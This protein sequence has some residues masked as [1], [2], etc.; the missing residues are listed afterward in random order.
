MS[1]GE[2]LRNE[3]RLLR[4]KLSEVEVE[5][6]K[7]VEV[8]ERDESAA[9]KKAGKTSTLP[10]GLPSTAKK[11]PNQ[12]TL[13][14]YPKHFLDTKFC[15][16]FQNI[17]SFQQ[18]ADDSSAAQLIRQADVN[19]LKDAQAGRIQVAHNFK[20]LFNSA[21]RIA[22]LNTFRQVAGAGRYDFMNFNRNYLDDMVLL[23]RT[24][25]HYVHHVSWN[26][27]SMERKQPGKYKETAE[28][29]SNAKNDYRML[30]K[31]FLWLTTSPNATRKSSKMQTPTAM[32]NG[33]LKKIG[34]PFEPFC[35]GLLNESPQTTQKGNP[36]Q[37]CQDSQ[38]SSSQLLSSQVVAQ[39][40]SLIQRGPFFP[41]IIQHM[42]Q[43]SNYLIV[44]SPN[45]NLPR[46]LNTTNS[47]KIEMKKMARKRTR[48]WITITMP[49]SKMDGKWGN[50]YQSDEDPDY[51]EE[52][53]RQKMP[54]VMRKWT[55]RR[56]ILTMEDEDEMF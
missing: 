30:D 55:M 16:H 42:T 25:N 3:D 45:K 29:K 11:K 32:M 26:K 36:L 31:I 52:L 50:L 8:F 41:K 27:F 14:D 24:Y 23:I 37:N 5:D 44:S 19:T 54:T 12:M 4:L 56:N 10:K 33:M 7:Q 6:G 43:P 28:S 35:T 13:E 48:M 53:T 51:T 20:A 1:L 49:R 18:H 15:K 46:C 21:C 38:V 17:D 2:G 39:H 34:S 9:P 22:A 47:I 40:S